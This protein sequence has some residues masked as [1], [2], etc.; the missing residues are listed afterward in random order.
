MKKSLFVTFS[1][2]IIASVVLSACGS[3]AATPVVIEQTKIVNGTPQTIVITA[4]PENQVPTEFKS[5]DPSTFVVSTFGEPDTLDPALAYDNASG[6]IL[7]NTY[8]TLVFYKRESFTELIPQLAMEVPSGENGGIS[9]DGKTYTFKIR[10]GVKF[11]NGDELT[12][13]DVAYTFQRGVLFG[14]S[15]SP[16]WLFAEPILGSTNN[17]DITDQ[18]DPDGSKGLMDNREALAK[19]D[20]AA[21][22]ATCQKVV[23]AIVPDNAAG[24]VTFHLAQPWGP[25]LVTLAGT[26]GSIQDQK[27]VSTNGGWDGSCDTWQKFYG[28]TSSELAATPLGTQENGTGPFKLDH[29]T[30]TEE[31]ALAANENYWR[32]EPAWEGGPTGAATLKKVIIKSMDEFSTRLASFQAGDADFVQV[33]SQADWPQMDSITGELCDPKSGECQPGPKPASSVRGYHG[34]DTITR[35]DAFLNFEVDTTGGNNFIGSGQVDGN[36]IPAN[37]FSDVHIRKAFAYC[38][39]YETYIKD[40]QQGEGFQAYNVML[41]GQIGDDPN[42]PHYTYDADKCAE[43]FKASTWKSA[44]GKSLWDTGFR[45]TIAYNTGNTSR[46]TVAEIFQNSISAINENFVIETTGLPWAA[47]LKAYQAGKLPMF[48]IG[49]IEDIP[50]PHNWTFTYTLGA[51]GSKQGL[52]TEL[53]NQFRPIVQQGAGETDPQKRAE[54][55][56]QFNQLF[57][58]QVPTVLLSQAYTRHYE[59]RWVKGYYSNPIYSNFYYYALSK[60]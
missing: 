51:Y 46:Q 56:K 18:L 28:M 55:Y 59:Q 22:K 32:T 58:D 35:T 11:H 42:G 8:D 37:F 19:E 16:Q 7:Q 54:T 50:D 29:W 20:P 1:L 2:L 10:T 26:W 3:A 36:G 23:D 17:N 44:D 48:V 49:W 40:V 4:T 53:K 41:K 9:A 25:F 13:T 21:L 47:Y 31:V 5:K 27:W 39:D 57:Y 34:L 52:P 6:E 30:P 15:T 33:G 43:E 12:P 14:G 38:F 60:Q 45:M 24:T